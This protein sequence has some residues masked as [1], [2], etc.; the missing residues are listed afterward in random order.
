VDTITVCVHIQRDP[1][2]PA[3]RSLSGIDMLEG[4]TPT[5]EWDLSPLG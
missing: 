5:G 1:D 4:L 2:N 3:G